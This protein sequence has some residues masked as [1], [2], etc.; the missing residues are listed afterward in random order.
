[1]HRRTRRQTGRRG[2]I[3]YFSRPLHLIV[4]KD[5]ILNNTADLAWSI[6]DHR[7][8]TDQ[9]KSILYSIWSTSRLSLSLH[10][11]DAFLSCVHH[12]L[13]FLWT[14]AF[15]RIVLTMRCLL[16]VRATPERGMESFHYPIVESFTRES[17]TPSHLPTLTSASFSPSCLL[18]PGVS[19][20]YCGASHCM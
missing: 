15:I 13:S 14:S 8:G 10:L 4:P 9:V 11:P 3:H 19:E 16:R 18:Q 12:I 2:G 6:W 17:L 7:N 5:T 20:W 1:M